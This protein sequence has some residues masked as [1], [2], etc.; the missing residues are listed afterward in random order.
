[1][2]GI[3]PRLVAIRVRMEAVAGIAVKGSEF[4][5]EERHEAGGGGV[6][7]KIKRT[8]FD[9]IVIHVQRQPGVEFQGM[10]EFAVAHRGGELHRS[11]EVNGAHCVFL[12]RQDIFNLISKR[13]VRRDLLLMYIFEC[14][15]HDRCAVQDSRYIIK[16]AVFF[17]EVRRAVPG[18]GNFNK[19]FVGR[20]E[21]VKFV[22]AAGVRHP[23]QVVFPS[24]K[25][26]YFGI[27]GL[28]NP[29]PGPVF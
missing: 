11:V 5:L 27:H 10:E 15:S 23:L 29:C 6:V 3:A 28:Q 16:V 13:V 24:A 25:V 9:C 4:V 2:E 8:F 22:D 7:R 14:C 21:L 19:A 1:M 12:G 18:V 26:N 20:I 17:T